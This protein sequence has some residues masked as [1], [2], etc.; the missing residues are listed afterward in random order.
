MDEIESE[1]TRKDDIEELCRLF[2]EYMEEEERV[3]G[4]RRPA[5]GGAGAPTGKRARDDDETGG[6]SASTDVPMG[7]LELHLE[8]EFEAD[9]W[10]LDDVTVQW[11][12]GG[13][14]AAARKEE[15][16]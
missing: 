10:A 11:L 6:A 12:K 1:A 14:V 7:S 9:E 2:T 13:K 4:K 16:Q 15:V 3:T 8:E 5:E